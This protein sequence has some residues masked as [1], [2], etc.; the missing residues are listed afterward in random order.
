MNEWSVEIKYIMESIETHF[1]SDLT[2]IDRQNII[3]VFE[4]SLQDAYNDGISDTKYEYSEEYNY[5]DGF[6]DGKASIQ[7]NWISKK[8]VGVLLKS[9]KAHDYEH[10]QALLGHCDIHV[11]IEE[12]KYE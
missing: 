2:E 8:V 6:E 1:K 10:V 12:L 7:D 9:L 11:T 4:A 3:T 5:Y